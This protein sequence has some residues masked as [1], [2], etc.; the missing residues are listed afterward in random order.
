[1]NI[2]QVQVPGPLWLLILFMLHVF[3]G[4]VDGREFDCTQ[5]HEVAATPAGA[6]EHVDCQDCH[7]EIEVPHRS[8]KEPGASQSLTCSQCHRKPDREVSRSIHGDAVSCTDCHGGAHDVRHADDLRS[9]TSPVNQIKRCGGCHDEPPTLIGSYLASVHGR[10][11]LVSGLINAPSCSD[12]HGGHR[13]LGVSVDRAS[14]SRSNGPQTCGECHALLLDDW[15]R[16][17]AH[18]KAWKNGEPGPRCTTCHSSHEIEDPRSREARLT[19]AENCGSCHTEYLMSFRDSFHG[20]ANSLGFVQGATCSDCHTPHK[21]SSASD[22]RSSVHPDNLEKT[23]GQCHGKA[24]AS[25]VTFD[26][27][28]DPSDATDS[29]PVYLVWLFMTALLIGVF[30]F[31]GIHDLRCSDHWLASCGANTNS[32]PARMTDM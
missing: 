9:E 17:S 28:N 7:G 24:T 14:T 23:C 29:Y 11:L 3:P 5:C 13:I 27:H 32:M 31:F 18:G 12:C 19:S 21:N 6:H 20:K 22:P 25:F 30:A 2:H 26:P 16:L 8:A 1:M 10:A 4:V 15:V